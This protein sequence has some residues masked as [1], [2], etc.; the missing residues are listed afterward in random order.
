MNSEEDFYKK[1]IKTNTCWI[2]K[3]TVLSS[4]YGVIRVQGKIWRAHRYSYFLANG[5]INPNLVIMH[6]CDNKLCVNPTH[7]SQGTVKDNVLDM[8]MKGR[9]LNG[10]KQWMSKLTEDQVRSIRLEYIP[11][12][13]SARKIAKKYGMSEIEIS[14]IVR[15]L[16]WK[17][18]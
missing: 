6:S 14:K 13:N 9:T 5:E 17:H 3:G 16:K 2:W 11:Y 8:V 10:E 15:R 1:I 4:G 18:I 12:K 7:L